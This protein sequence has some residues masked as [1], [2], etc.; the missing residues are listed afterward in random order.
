MGSTTSSFFKRVGKSRHAYLFLAPKLLVFLALMLAPFLA[1]IVMSFQTGGILQSLRFAGF[2]N[3]FNILRDPVFWVSIQNTFVYSAIVIA[4]SLVLSLLVAWQLVG[5]D[6]LQSLL[7]ACVILPTLGSLVVVSAIWRMMLFPKTGIIPS[8]FSALGLRAVNWFGD[9]RL[10]LVTVGVV[11]VWW[12]VGF[13]SMIFLAAL[14]A[15]PGE[16]YDSAR[17]DGAGRARTFFQI[18]LPLI[19]PSVLFVLVMATIWNLQAFDLIYT[20]THGGPGYATTTIVYYI[21]QKAFRIDDMGRAATMSVAILII[22]F[23]ITLLQFKVF[24]TKL[25]Y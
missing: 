2:R 21:Y 9:Q 15:I 5:V 8:L 6:S 20:M 14:R 10:A 25:E 3:Y 16:L 4:G 1:T 22:V 17:I 12:G 23:A 7:R 24:K 18:S 11:D 19:K 13:Y